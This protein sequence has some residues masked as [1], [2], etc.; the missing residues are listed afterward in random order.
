MGGLRE[1]GVG[2][3]FLFFFAFAFRFVCARSLAATLFV[4]FDV[5]LLFRTLDAFDATF[6]LVGT[7]LS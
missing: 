5:F 3:Y 2:S 4:A 1:P 6:L 7:F